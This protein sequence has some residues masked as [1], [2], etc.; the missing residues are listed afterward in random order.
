M[1]KEDSG[2]I[3]KGNNWA[4]LI[5]F[6]A[7]GKPKKFCLQKVKQMLDLVKISL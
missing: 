1:I 2:K 3:F 7:K 4:I 6:E 5:G